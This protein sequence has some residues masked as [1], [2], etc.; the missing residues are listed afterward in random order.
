M[1]IAFLLGAAGLG[2]L[3][4]AGSKKTPSRPDTAPGQPSP[5]PGTPPPSGGGGSCFVPGCGGNMSGSGDGLE[6]AAQL[7]GGPTPAREKAILEAVERGDAKIDWSTVR[8]SIPGYSG[9][10]HVFARTMRIGQTN[11]VRVQVNYESAQRLCDMLGCAMMTPLVADKTHEQSI[12][13]LAAMPMSDWVLDRTMANTNRMVEYSQKLDKLVDPRD[14]R[15]VSNESKHWVVTKRFWADPDPAKRFPPSKRSAN[16]GWWSKQAPNGRLW[17]STGL[18]HDWYHTDYSQQVVLMSQY[19]DIDGLGSV[20][21]GS[22][23]KHPKLHALLSNEGPLES[24]AH[25]AFNKTSPTLDI[26]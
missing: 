4:L 15:L 5:G 7:P 20:H 21:V 13:K 9:T 14:I 1:N 2:L 26:A 8:V 3:A 22:V 10:V 25:P 23:L 24:W 6:W 17:Q 16:Y 12:V 19:M 18:A 11:P